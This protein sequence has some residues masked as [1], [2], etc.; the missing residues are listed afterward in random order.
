VDFPTTPGAFDSSHNGGS[1]DRL[2][3]FVTKLDSSGARVLNSTFLGGRESD[4]G[5][6][7]AVDDRGNTYVIGRTASPD[8][9]TRHALQDTYHQSSSL[10]DAFLVKLNAN[11]TTI[12][13]ST[14]LG[15]NNSDEGTDILVDGSGHAYVLARGGRDFPR[16]PEAFDPVPG[17][18]NVFIAKI[19]D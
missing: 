1:F 12:F 3:A 18:G 14:Y 13:Y 16:T 15:G 4:S 2:D 8:F 19:A 10:G 11:G 9:P 17:G 7:V 5:R 6:A